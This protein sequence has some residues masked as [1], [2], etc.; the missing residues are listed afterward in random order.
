MPIWEKYFQLQ[1]REHFGSNLYNAVVGVT[2]ADNDKNL[3]FV[4]LNDLWIVQTWIYVWIK[5]VMFFLCKRVFIGCC[6]RDDII[7]HLWFSL[8]CFQCP[9]LTRL[10]VNLAWDHELKTN[11]KAIK[12]N[13]AIKTIKASRISR[14]SR[15]LRLSSR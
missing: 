14:L 8:N 11:N 1:L 15:L 7:R 5:S 13:K 9:I 10:K 3:S 2:K 12:A 6:Y 4:S